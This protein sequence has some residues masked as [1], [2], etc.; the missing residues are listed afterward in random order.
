MENT[1]EN[2]CVACK[3][4]NI[5]VVRGILS[6]KE[7]DINDTDDEDFTPLMAAMYND[8]VDI[9]KYLFSFPELQLG[10]MDSEGTALH[11]ASAK[12]NVSAVRL[13]CQDRRCTPSIINRKNR[14]GETALMCAGSADVMEELDK[15]EGIDFRIK[16]IEGQT[17]MD[18]ARKG[19]NGAKKLEYLLQRNKKVES[20]KV[21]AANSVANRMKKSSDIAYLQ[22]PHSLHLLVA[23]FNAKFILCCRFCEDHLETS[24]DLMIHKKKQHKEKVRKC[25][26]NLEGACRYGEERCW[27]IHDETRAPK[28]TCNFCGKV[29]SC[30][31]DLLLHKRDE[32]R[33][34]VQPCRNGASCKFKQNCW[35]LHDTQRE[36]QQERERQLEG[37][38][39]MLQNMAVRLANIGRILDQHQA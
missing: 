25:T 29:T 1:I 39:D 3:D 2:L 37:M 30:I 28:P 26:K 23:G 19:T 16:N 22:I 36:R 4:G 32:H 5:Q 18:V 8:Q 13:F 15:V 31:N 9:V 14:W 27:F 7:V 38:V 20:L 34:A 21:I 33:S 35:F 11:W 10:K 12:G 17:L 6:S 24:Q